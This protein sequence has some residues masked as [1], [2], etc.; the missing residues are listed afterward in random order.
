MDVF[1][2]LEMRSPRWINPVPRGSVALSSDSRSL[3]LERIF[4]DNS[5]SRTLWPPGSSYNSRFSRPADSPALL[6]EHSLAG[7]FTSY[8]P[9][10]FARRLLH[11]RLRLSCSKVVL[12]SLLHINQGPVVCKP[13][14]DGTLLAAFAADGDHSH[15][16]Q[17]LPVGIRSDSLLG[18]FALIYVPSKFAHLRALVM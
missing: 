13:R 10:P 17:R 18:S 6:R 9:P 7:F 2:P 15:W 11:A 8:Q 14:G 1:S 12:V 4:R 16:R 5:L 3:D